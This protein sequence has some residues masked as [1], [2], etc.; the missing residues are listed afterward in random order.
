MNLH[1]PDYFPQLHGRGV[2][3]LPGRCGTSAVQT[4]R[5]VHALDAT[6][7]HGIFGSGDKTQTTNNTQVGASEQATQLYASGFSNAAGG[8]I[9]S[10]AKKVD[11]IDN[12]GG[13]FAL[14]GVTLGGSNTGTITVNG[15]A[16]SEALADKFTDA[17][18][19]ITDQS[20]QSVTAALEKVSTLAENKQTNGGSS[21]GKQLLIGLG[22]LVGGGV[23][24]WIVGKV[25][26][27]S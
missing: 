1:D 24:A 4:L 22:I 6:R 19:A 21:L 2:R 9:L 10:G 14:G 15:A 26:K 12:T 25:F 8:D 7:C 13:A 23:C 11:G 20:G 27:K 16:G 17:I 18:K 3:P 5:A